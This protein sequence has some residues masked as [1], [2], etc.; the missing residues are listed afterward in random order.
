MAANDEIAIAEDVETG[1]SSS[2]A[3]SSVAQDDAKRHS[4]SASER[5]WDIDGDGRL[6]KTEKALKDM[7]AEG[8]GTLTKEQMANLMRQNMAVQKQLGSVKKVVYALVAFTVVL[9]LANVGVSFA[10]AYLAKDTTVN[11]GKLAD[12]AGNAVATDTTRTTFDLDAAQDSNINEY[13]RELSRALNNNKNSVTSATG[14]DVTQE[15]NFHWLAADDGAAFVEACRRG[16]SASFRKQWAH[17]CESTHVYCG[18]GA[19]GAPVIGN[20]QGTKYLLAV[21]N[22]PFNMKVE[23]ISTENRYKVHEVKSGIGGCCRVGQD[24]CHEGLCVEG[25]CALVVAVDEEA[26]ATGGVEG[27]DSTGGSESIAGS[28]CNCGVEGSYC[29]TDNGDCGAELEC[30]H[31]PECVDAL[32]NYSH[33]CQPVEEEAV[34][35]P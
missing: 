34:T 28:G 31:R 22:Q 12:K 1:A 16:G 6:G 13:D 20:A 25:Q 14:L 5:R 3:P 8:K 9:A 29:Y 26:P 18:N 32:C 2:S 24:D 15:N 35:A 10:A 19:P 17:G 33:H 21:E 30:V 27:G 7:D 23:W 4:L 11:D